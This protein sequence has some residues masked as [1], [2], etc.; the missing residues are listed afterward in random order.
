MK[1]ED[2]PISSAQ[3]VKEGEENIVV[4][5]Q[6]YE[7]IKAACVAFEKGIYK[8]HRLDYP[9]SKEVKSAEETIKSYGMR[10]DDMYHID[11]IIQAMEFFAAQHQQSEGM[12]EVETYKAAL[13]QIRRVEMLTPE[14]E[15]MINK[16]LNQ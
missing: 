1:K 6:N 2:K 3:P 10:S 5:A 15:A 13:R 9:A 7:E 11:T 12:V 16:L 4:N 14:T 8:A